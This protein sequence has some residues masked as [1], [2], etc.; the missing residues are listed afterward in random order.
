MLHSTIMFDKYVWS[1]LVAKCQS[2]YQRHG[3]GLEILS[4]NAS[5]PV[6]VS[7][8]TDMAKNVFRFVVY[9]LWSKNQSN[10]F[11]K[12]VYT[13]EVDETEMSSGSAPV[14]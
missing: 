11:A 14:P 6:E 5:D 13:C 9:I 7:D 2:I 1:A 12:A 4:D 3:L 8:Q 10:A